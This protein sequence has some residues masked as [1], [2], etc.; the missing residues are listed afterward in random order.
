MKQGWGT[1][2]GP[3]MLSRWLPTW[4]LVNIHA[5]ANNGTIHVYSACT[6]SRPSHTCMSRESQRNILKRYTHDAVSEVHWDRHDNVR[7]G[8]RASKEQTRLS[9]LLPKLMKLGRAGSRSDRA[10]SEICRLVDQITP[11][12]GMLPRDTGDESVEDPSATRVMTPEPLAT[13]VMP[14]E[15]PKAQNTADGTSSD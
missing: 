6:L 9:K 15:Q 5:N 14:A 10:Y 3:N 7:I 11:G 4:L 2:V 12:I 1:S 13:G 8:Q